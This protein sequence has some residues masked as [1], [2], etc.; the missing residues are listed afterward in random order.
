MNL[1]KDFKGLSFRERYWDR[2]E[3][4]TM[5]AQQLKSCTPGHILLKNKKESELYKEIKF[6]KLKKGLEFFF[7]FLP[8]VK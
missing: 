7:L 8:V 1:K 2:E 5:P 3:H 4:A 6:G